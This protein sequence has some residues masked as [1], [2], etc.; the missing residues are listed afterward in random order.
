MRERTF[1]Y[2]LPGLT[3]KPSPEQLA[4]AGLDAVLGDAP[5]AHTP[6]SQARGPSGGPGMVL[7][8]AGKRSPLYKADRQEWRDFGKFHLGWWTDAVPRPEELQREDMLPGH[9]VKL[10]D[11][12]EWLV[13]CVNLLPI[14]MTWSADQGWGGRQQS[15]HH[16][17]LELRDTWLQTLI[18]AV[19]PEQPECEVE[20]EKEPEALAGDEVALSMVNAAEQATRVLAVNY[21]VGPAELISLHALTS[22]TVADVLNHLCDL[23]GLKK[24]MGTGG[25][26]SARG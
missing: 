10:G 6:I 2:F 16:W 20:S 18:E 25:S 14:E 12:N 1:I 15:V 23:P 7:A 11:G 21:H 3:E 22:R 5:L 9:R 24:K 26:S 8:V 13:P 17:L 19:R 4:S